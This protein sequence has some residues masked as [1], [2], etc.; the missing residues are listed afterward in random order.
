MA[1][2]TERQARALARQQAAAEKAK[3]AYDAMSPERK[4]RI[5]A[6]E[7]AKADAVA[8]AAAKRAANKGKTKFPNLGIEVPNSELNNPI[9]K[10]SNRN[11][12]GIAKASTVNPVYN[13]YG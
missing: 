11:S 12:G 1:S 5:K 6:A 3:A 13:T 2:L 7:K 4:A 9:Y 10:Y 8:A